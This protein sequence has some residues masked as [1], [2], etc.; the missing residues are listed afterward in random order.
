MSDMGHSNKKL[1]IEEM[2]RI[3][4]DRDGICLSSE[5]INNH[6]K[7]KWQCKRGHI[8][9]AMPNSIKCGQWCPYCAGKAKLTIDEM[10]NLAE[11]HKG[12]CLST[13]YI[14]YETKLEWEC[15]EGHIWKTTPGNIKAGKWCPK[16]ATIK[17]AIKAKGKH[18][19]PDTE[20]KVGH[21]PTMGAFK[22]GFRHPKE[23]LDRISRTLKGKH[24]NPET[25]FKLGQHIS[26]ETEF[27]KGDSRLMGENNPNW[28]GGKS[29][30]IYP[31]EF[32]DE[33][34][35]K[36]RAR[37]NW[38][39]QECHMTQDELGYTLHVHHIDYEKHNNIEENLISLCKSCHSKTNVWNREDWTKY[40][41]DKL[42]E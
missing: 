7:L 6:T 11:S 22:I 24:I 41:K 39:C 42:K 17:N 15:K 26:P 27:K 9:E 12:K 10:Q 36:I 34:K 5:Y 3:S 18:F 29:F 38:T 30:E 4:E 28:H 23:I 25:E 40:Y 19:S 8:W 31:Q 2:Q 21:P 32:N 1:T 13:K 14:N 16:C 20:F 33:L 35:E 37:D